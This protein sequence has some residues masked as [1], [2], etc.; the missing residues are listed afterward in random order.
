VTRLS[1]APVIR[2]ATY[3]LHQSLYLFDKIRQEFLAV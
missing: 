3:R 2:R 1:I